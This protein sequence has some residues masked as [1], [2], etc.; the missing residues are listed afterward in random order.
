MSHERYMRRAIQLAKLGGR[1]TKT[2][3][4][5]GAVI[6][7]KGQIIGEGYHEYYGGAHAE[8]NAIQSVKKEDSHLLSESTMYVTL[9]PCNVH[10]K[11]PPCSELLLRYQIKRLYIGCFDPS[12]HLSGKSAEWM[13]KQG[14]EVISP[15]LEK[16]CQ[17]I[18]LP[19]KRHLIDRRPYVIIKLAKSKD[20]YMGKEGQQVWISNAQAKL[21]AH[22]L[23][24]KVD[25]ILVGTNTAATDNPKL[26]TR[27][28][29]G[30]SPLRIVLDRR[31][32]LDANLYIYKDELPCLTLTESLDSKKYQKEV[33][34]L[35]EW[36]EEKILECLFKRGIYT[37]LVEGGRQVL[38]SLIQKELWD[39]AHVIEG[40]LYLHQGIQAPNVE[41]RLE[42]TLKLGSNKVSILF[43]H[44]QD[45]W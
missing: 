23:R 6:V 3:P 45:N 17:Q 28:I 13:R 33:I 44:P 9:E 7:H 26:T 39:E 37:L 4:K 21:Y 19:F 8:P 2:N 18:I 38:N 40:D 35:E 34:R 12:D 10:G 5:V 41:G 30:D 25:G 43:K 1:R 20:H 32:R 14:I 42:S 29:D 36:T 27:E 15:L 31:L 24:D 16:E 11:T 22:S